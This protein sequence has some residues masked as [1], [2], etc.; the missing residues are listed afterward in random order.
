MYELRHTFKLTSQMEK[1]E[2]V[3]YSAALAVTGTLHEKYMMDLA[4]S[5]STS[6]VGADV[7]FSF[8]RV[9]T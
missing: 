7:S 6:V 8:I 4:G 5:R 9:A 1:L 2:T 3:Q